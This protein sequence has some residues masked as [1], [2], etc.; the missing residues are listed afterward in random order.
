[1]VRSGNQPVQQ[2]VAKIALKQEK[3]IKLP[4]VSQTPLNL[5]FPNNV[6][7]LNDPPCCFG[8]DGPVPIM[9]MA[10]CVEKVL[11]VRL[12]LQ[13]ADIFTVPL[14]SRSIQSISSQ[15][16]KLFSAADLNGH[17]LR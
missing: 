14:A 9:I 10:E 7:I 2:I 17:G 5:N 3:A 12:F 15:A 4:S 1:M 11:A 13:T 6:F 16:I 8:A